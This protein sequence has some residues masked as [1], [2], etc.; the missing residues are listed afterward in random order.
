MNLKEQI[1]LINELREICKLIGCSGLSE[2]CFTHPQ[3][4]KIIRKVIEC[5][6]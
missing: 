4:C 3:E 1:K 2:Q 5:S 6:K